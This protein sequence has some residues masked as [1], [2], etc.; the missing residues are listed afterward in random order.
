MR[1][2]RW[3]P[4]RDG[5]GGFLGWFFPFHWP[6]APGGSALPM[7]PTKKRGGTLRARLLELWL[8]FERPTSNFLLR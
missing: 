8:N 2:E 1:G 7:R 4:R 5:K 3:M 6:G